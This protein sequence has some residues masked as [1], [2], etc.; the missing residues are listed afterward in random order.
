MTC[1]Q[2]EQS[3]NKDLHCLPGL[4]CGATACRATA[5]GASE[6]ILVTSPYGS[7]TTMI[8]GTKEVAVTTGSLL[9]ACIGEEQQFRANG[10]HRRR[11]NCACTVFSRPT[12][13]TCP[14]RAWE[15]HKSAFA[16]RCHARSASHRNAWARA[17]AARTP[18]FWPPA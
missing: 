5:L 10:G 11:A 2:V 4:G 3:M 18:P 15:G 8:V 12:P 1:F 14:A 7:T 9:R 16:R 13:K 17:H 6:S